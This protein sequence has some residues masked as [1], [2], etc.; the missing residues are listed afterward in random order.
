[1]MVSA[2]PFLLLLLIS[3]KL[4]CS[5]RISSAIITILSVIN[6]HVF[7]FHGTPFLAS[8][9]QNITTA[10]NVLPSYHLVFDSIVFRLLLITIIE[11]FI[12]FVTQKV[13]HIN[14]DIKRHYSLLLCT[15][16]FLILWILFF[17]KWTLYPSSLVSWSWA[18]PMQ[19]H[20]YEICFVNSIYTSLNKYQMTEG[21][22]PEILNK[23]IQE[24]TAVEQPNEY[25]DIFL[26]L[27]ESLCDLN[28]TS[29]ISEGADVLKAIDRIPSIVKGY[30]V[31][32]MIGGGTNC[33]EYELL[34]SNSFY[35]IYAASPFSALDMEKTNSVV[36]YLNAFGYKST[37]MHCYS[38]I[39]Y[40]RNTAYPA[41]G[42]DN[43]YL[44]PDFFTYHL[45]ENREWL[46]IDNYDDML[47]YYNEHRDHPQFMYLL[48]FQNH[49]GYE[50]NSPS[51]DTVQ[52]SNDFGEITDDLNEYLSSIQKSSEAFVYLIDKLTN[53][54]KP[55]IVLM[56]GDHAPSFISEM[57]VLSKTNIDDSVIQRTVPF[58]LWSNYELRKDGLTSTTTMSDLLP[59]LFNTANFPLSPYYKIINDLHE[60]VPVRTSDGLYYDSNNRKIE[61][62]NDSQYYEMIRD[63]YYMEYN[64]LNHGEDYNEEL[65][66]PHY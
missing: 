21:Y 48:T 45:Y 50:Q 63:Y 55:V 28:Y 38:D 14:I 37:A 60:T 9:F 66:A 4:L 64:N 34:T 47:S 12:I 17:S 58:Y 22:D 13:L 56:V 39:N 33:S 26:I 46:D 18:K 36:S 41:L 43:V 5:L 20:G 61:F 1:M 32:P 65:F 30:T 10:I 27:N 52:V 15:A 7:L 42:F 57:P 2:I 35:Q 25:P 16:D 8:D 6:Y 62:S 11:Y 29:G 51:S 24:N 3:G 44:G 49:G 23:Y 31:V 54:E 53:S 59:V 19:K 40:S